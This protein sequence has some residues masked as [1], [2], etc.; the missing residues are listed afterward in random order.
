MKKRK[1][2]IGLVGGTMLYSVT[3]LFGGFASNVSAHPH[4]E[5]LG[6]CA[7]KPEPCPNPIYEGDFFPG[8]KFPRGPKADC[9]DHPKYS[10]GIPDVSFER[11]PSECPCPNNYDPNPCPTPPFP[12]P[13]PYEEIKQERNSIDRV[14]IGLGERLE[15]MSEELEGKLIACG[16]C[17]HDPWIPTEYCNC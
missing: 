2:L 14:K 11:C 4:P 15:W 9:C 8:P 17:G 3:T 6:G 12:K 13:H 5:P 7:C 10:P 16:K 1:A